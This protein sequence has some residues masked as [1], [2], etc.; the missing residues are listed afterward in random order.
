ME[1][2]EVRKEVDDARVEVVNPVMPTLLLPSPLLSAG[3]E[4]IGGNLNEQR[5]VDLAIGLVA[6][7]IG[8]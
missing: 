5:D 3:G 6:G 4:G 7:L 2:R 1:E 8:D